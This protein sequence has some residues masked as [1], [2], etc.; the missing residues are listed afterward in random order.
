MKLSV[1]TARGLRQYQE[2]RYLVHHAAD[3]ILLAVMDGHG[4]S[5]VAEVCKDYLGPFWNLAVLT[6]E[7]EAR[8]YDKAL[9]LTIW[10]LE[11]ITCEY[12]SGSTISLA[13][14]PNA[15]DQVY[16]ASL[17]DSPIVVRTPDGVC[18]VSEGHN[19]RTNLAE[20]DAAIGRG[21]VYDGGYIWEPYGH[22]GL[23]MA[24]ALGDSNMGLVLSR[25]P[26]VEV[27]PLGDFVLLATDG[28]FDP[29]HKNERQ[30]IADVVALIDQG[31]EAQAIV[32]RAVKLPTDDNATAVLLT[33]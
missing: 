14:V 30:A 18:R 2:D 33:R 1:A 23:Q 12:H 15:E 6:K 17:G 8:L 25:E 16:V 5:D 13:F 10:Q 19:V 22:S 32:D 29:G 20:R 7:G 31:G 27:I 9:A 26:D 28:V 3:G 21:G 24:R 4:G 11:S